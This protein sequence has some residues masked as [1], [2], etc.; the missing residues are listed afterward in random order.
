MIIA[1]ISL[2]GAYGTYAE[3]RNDQ[4]KE[5]L[6]G[7]LWLLL[8]D[9]EMSLREAATAT[10]SGDLCAARYGVA[11]ANT[12]LDVIAHHS[13]GIEQLGQ[14]YSRFCNECMQ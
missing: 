7:Q 14:D 10:G 6:W 4:G 1:G 5:R 8:E 13:M 2:N 12:Y 9:A 3:L 11:V